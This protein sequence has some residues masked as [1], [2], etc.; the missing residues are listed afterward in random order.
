MLLKDFPPHPSLMGIVKCFRIVHFTS[1]IQNSRFFKAYPPKPELCLH[2]IL[3]GEMSLA[4]SDQT[5]IGF[6][7][8][9]ALIGQ[10]TGVMPRITVGEFLNFQVVFH[11]SAIFRITGIPATEL[12]DQLLPA[13]SI[14]PGIRP[15][16]EQLKGARSYTEL[17]SIG[18]RIASWITKPNCNTLHPVDK[19]IEW[20]I[21]RDGL[22]SL[23]WMAGE[24]CLSARQFNRTFQNRMGVNPKTYLRL[25]RFIRAYNTKNANPGWD[26]LRV[27]VEANYYDYQHLVKDYQSFTGQTP[28]GF[29]LLEQESPECQL[30]LA[31]PVYQ[32][33]F[34][35]MQVC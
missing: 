9:M 27:A 5:I 10:Q 12:V 11:S 14:F 34:R 2:F 30:G 32:E 16:F 6:P 19:A 7:F 4:L 24:A 17:V 22:V 28:T 15:F 20:M 25:M 18:E 26:W 33:R 13:D 23:D 35:Q 31:G 3:K 21:Q 8:P 1:P 29:H